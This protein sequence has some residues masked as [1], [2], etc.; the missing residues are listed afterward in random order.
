[1]C[2]AE[3]PC[4]QLLPKTQ[5]LRSQ[6]HQ[7]RWPLAVSFP[8]PL[9]ALPRLKTTTKEEPQNF[10]FLLGLGHREKTGPRAAL[11]GHLLFDPTLKAPH[12]GRGQTQVWNFCLKNPPKCNVHLKK[13]SAASHKHFFS[14]YYAL[15]T[16]RSKRLWR[17]NNTL[18]LVLLYHIH[19]PALAELPINYRVHF[20]GALPSQ[21]RGPLQ[22]MTLGNDTSSSFLGLTVSHSH[23]ETRSTIHK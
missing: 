4:R 9:P 12:W 17:N 10:I 19:S 23:L 20:A 22:K 16:E 3:R 1:M 18:R 7:H 2:P 13:K 6:Q 14:L 5:P 8:P 15:E 11:A 21:V